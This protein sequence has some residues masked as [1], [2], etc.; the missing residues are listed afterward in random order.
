[1]LRLSI[2]LLISCDDRD[3]GENG[4]SEAAGLLTLIEN[5]LELEWWCWWHCR[6]YEWCNKREVGQ[7]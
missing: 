4:N 7:S 5:I 6:V 2:N 1:M 3:D